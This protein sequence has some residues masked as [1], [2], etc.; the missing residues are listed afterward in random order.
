MG[1][2]HQRKSATEKIFP[3]ATAPPKPPTGPGVKMS[4]AQKD[5]G[6]PIPQP[7]A[8][9]DSN[10]RLSAAQK[11]TVTHRAG[12]VV[13]ASGE[14]QKTVGEKPP[15]KPAKPAQTPKKKTAATEGFAANFEPKKPC[16]GCPD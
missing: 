5:A 8:V 4:A 9:A 15:K 11:D 16:S 10:G 12:T 2:R 13:K 14:P 6:K 7:G 1:I 3:P